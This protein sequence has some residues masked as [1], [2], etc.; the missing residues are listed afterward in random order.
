MINEINFLLTVCISSSGLS[1]DQ[2]KESITNSG[3]GFFEM[4]SSITLL[5]I[6]FVVDK[7]NS[8]HIL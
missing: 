3:S 5:I 7:L 1:F 6:L 8:N 4:F 2:S